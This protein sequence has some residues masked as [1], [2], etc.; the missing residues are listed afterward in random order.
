MF[1]GV[2]EAHSQE[3]PVPIP[4]QVSIILRVLAFDRAFE[5]NVPEEIVVGVVYQDGLRDSYTAMRA[6][7]AAIDEQAVGPHGQTLRAVPLAFQGAASLSRTIVEDGIDLLYVAPLRAVALD[8]LLEASRSAGI[9][10]ATGI[11]DLVEDGI[12]IGIGSRAGKPRIMINLDAA[13]ALGAEFGSEL[14]KL[15]QIVSAPEPPE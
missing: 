13:K 7:T 2:T 6:V 3:M 14:L 12:V 4:S 15:S 5:T 11:P 9:L 10:T 1:G 8:D